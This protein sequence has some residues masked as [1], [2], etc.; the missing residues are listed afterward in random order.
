MSTE[1][2]QNQEKEVVVLT[3]QG[4][5]ASSVSNSTQVTRS[6]SHR[7]KVLDIV[8]DW[9]SNPREDYGDEDFQI[10]KESIK[11]NGVKMPLTVYVDKS[12]GHTHLAH[13][14]RRMR[15]LT[16]LIAEGVTG[17]D[18]VNIVPTA[19]NEESILMDH[20]ILNN[21]KPLSDVETSRTLW[22]LKQR[23]GPNSMKEI[24]RRVG[25]PYQ[26]IVDYISYYE[27]G[28]SLSKEL[29]STKKMSM[30]TAMA[31]A[32]QT[33]GND[34]Q[35]K[36]LTKAIEQMKA[37][38]R[39]KIAPS[40]VPEIKLQ[41]RVDRVNVIKDTIIQLTMAE[42]KTVEVSALYKMMELLDKE[43]VTTEKLVELLTATEEKVTQ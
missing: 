30:T 22:Q 41:N 31:V 6:D 14:F 40:D 43:S 7:I 5:V 10:L 18:I 25:M 17:L 4:K 38:N 19:H 34:K 42:V 12:T 29:V 37:D 2:K 1:N 28:T 35:N 3:K 39:S 32:K 8:V 21:G 15:A 24:S 20:L 26:K 36:V 16:E 23:M 27:N 13:G 9:S 33:S 11:E